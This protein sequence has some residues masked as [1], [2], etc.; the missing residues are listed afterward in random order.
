MSGEYDADQGHE[1]AAE[2]P[3][4]AGT[5]G[6]RAAPKRRGGCVP[7]AM[8]AFLGLIIVGVVGFYAW[9]RVGGILGFAPDYSGPGS[10]QVTFEVNAGDSITAIGNNLV[11]AGVVKS[12]D[13]FV[14]AAKGNDK[15][16]GIQVGFYQLKKEMKAADALDILVDHQN[17]IKNRVLVKEGMRVRDILATIAK[18]SDISA[19]SLDEAMEH[20]AALGLPPEARGN[21]EGWLFPATYDVTPGMTATKLLTQMISKTKDTLEALDVTD[22]AKQKG[23]T[24]EE[25]LTVA[26]I[27]QLEANRSEDYPKVTRVIYNRLDAGMPLQLDSTV[28]Y[29]TGRKGDV[30]TTAAER[31][32][33][34]LYNTYKHAGLPPG[35]IG[36]PGKETIEAALNP[37]TGDWLYFVVDYESNQVLFT[38]SYSEHLKNVERTKEYCRKSDKC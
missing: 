8:A 31:Q 6:R 3:T 4:Q 17:L 21:P 23:L 22:R 14:N 38:S 7:I 24:V 18:E 15:A 28:S 2:A 11:T 29:L 33:D 20:P 30:W 1:P 34:S 37:A 25:V 35:P 16:T 13:A 9:D 27:A 5:P 10:G 26:S 12:T 32:S 19:K 36:S